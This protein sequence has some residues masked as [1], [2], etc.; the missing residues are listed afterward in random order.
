MF[1]GDEEFVLALVGDGQ[2]VVVAAADGQAADTAVAADAVVDVH[3]EVAAL[4]GAVVGD[5]GGLAEPAVAVAAFLAAENLVVV[6]HREFRLRKGEAAVQ[7]AEPEAHVG[8]LLEDLLQAFG[9]PLGLAADV[10]GVKLVRQPFDLLPQKGQ[11]ALKYAR[12]L[13]VEAHGFFEATERRGFEPGVRAQL[14]GEPLLVAQQLVGREVRAALLVA[15]VFLVRAG[16][17][18]VELFG[19]LV[20]LFEED[21]GFFEVFEEPVVAAVEQ[22]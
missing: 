5:G 2:A 1:D 14:C 15:F 16:Q 3:D 18:L 8:P 17:Y 9:L 4:E 6:E 21:Q 7:R 10:D 22:G 20:V 12:L 11:L 19:D 13:G